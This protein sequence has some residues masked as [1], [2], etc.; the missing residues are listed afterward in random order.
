M[1]GSSS[2]RFLCPSLL[3]QG[4][5]EA[6]GA[7]TDEDAELAESLIRS[8]GE[9]SVSRHWPPHPSATARGGIKGGAGFAGEA[10]DAGAW[11][12]QFT[13]AAGAVCLGEQ[14]IREAQ[15]A[16][17]TNHMYENQNPIPAGRI[18]AGGICDGPLRGPC[19]RH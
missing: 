5:P 2:Q 8:C 17:Q 14:P 19:C 7:F 1:N 13:R 9:N 6:G 12:K 15:T 4:D 3:L 10:L 18:V 11:Q 16:S